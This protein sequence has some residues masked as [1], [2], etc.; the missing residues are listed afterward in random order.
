MCHYRPPLKYTKKHVV[1]TENAS[2]TKCMM[3][4]QYIN[5]SVTPSLSVDGLTASSFTLSSALSSVA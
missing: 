4:S 5:Y 1:S 2:H 3:R